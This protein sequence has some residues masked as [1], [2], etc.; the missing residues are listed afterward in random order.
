ML[1]KLLDLDFNLNYLS[2]M[3]KAMFIVVVLLAVQASAQMNLVPNPSFEDTVACP[4]APENI[5]DA[6]F[7][8]SA[9]GSPDYFNSCCSYY[10]GVPNNFAG[11]QFAA[12]GNG[13]VGLAT[14]SAVS[15][16]GYR[17]IIGV[18]L[19]QSLT[20]GVRYYVSMVVSRADT[21]GNNCATNN[22]GFRFSTVEHNAINLNPVPID[23]MAHVNYPA[24]IF[25]NVT[26]H[27]ITGSFMADSTYDYL[28]VGNFF[29]DFNTDTAQCADIGYYFVDLLCVST[30][31]LMCDDPT[32][33]SEHH[34]MPFSVFPNPADSYIEIMNI[35]EM[36]RYQLIDVFGQSIESGQLTPGE[37]QINTTRLSTGM[38]LLFIE[39]QI[40]L[41]I[42]ISR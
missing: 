30:D 8:Y 9:S 5:I 20:V 34:N 32:G 13:Y 11:I 35:K 23:N 27:Q 21:A 36:T 26:W 17:E 28:M 4:V 33:V 12:Q 19:S 22:L 16:P 14:Y 24:I 6:T 7:Y 40:P 1:M 41:R 37:N 25:N 15:A 39:N 31:S 29:N 10:M 42:I 18:R 2:Y 38:Y 3:K